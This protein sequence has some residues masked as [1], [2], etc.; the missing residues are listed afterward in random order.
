MRA[1]AR[2]RGRGRPEPEFSA[3]TQILAGAA[4]A[5][6]AAGFEATSV[7]DVL[8]AAGVS[9]RTFYRCF[10]NKDELFAELAEAAAMMFLQSMRTAAS[11]GRTPLEK[12][13]N[14]VEVWLRA[15]AT[16]GP[17]FHVLAAEAAR[18]DSRMAG[19]RRRV[20]DALVAMMADGVRADSGRE[21]DPLLLRGLIG[22][23]DTIAAEAHAA[24]ADDPATFERA[25]AAMMHLLVAALQPPG[26]AADSRP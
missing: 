21:V 4:V 2:R 6:G 18:P 15:P 24:G 20:I 14:C 10:R 22:A 17:I 8:R 13:G 16:A 26:P 25:R 7:E 12:L 1:R 11:L 5:F 9:R 23:M 19:H 3:R